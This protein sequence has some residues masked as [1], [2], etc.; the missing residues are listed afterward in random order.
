[1]NDTAGDHL[2]LS[3]T[4]L[5]KLC[6]PRYKRVQDSLEPEEPDDPEHEAL[7]DMDFLG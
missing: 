7:D 6:I 1:M 3:E 4:E 2:D 5:E